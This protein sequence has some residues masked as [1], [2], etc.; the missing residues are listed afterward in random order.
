MRVSSVVGFSP[1]RSAAPPV[2]R[3]RQPGALEDPADVLP[4]DVNQPRAPLARCR[5]RVRRRDRQPSAGGHDHRA[6]DDIPEFTD[7]A[8]PGIVLER[9]TVVSRSIESIRLPNAFENSSTNRHT[10][11]GMSSTAFAKRRHVNREHV[12]PV[13]EVLSEGALGDPLFEIAMRRR[14]DPGVDGNRPRTAEP[15]DCP[16]FEHAQQLDLHVELADRRSRQERSS[17]DW[18][19]RSA[20]PVGRGLR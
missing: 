18:R 10:S 7:V 16:L 3:M 17:S 5:R 14:N 13:I 8:R 20:P 11:S 12:E 1:S 2:P 6:L 4:F 19:A 9:R 15:L